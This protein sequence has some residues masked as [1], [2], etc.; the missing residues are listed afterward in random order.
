M[1]SRAEILPE[2]TEMAELFSSWYVVISSAIGPV[3]GCPSSMAERRLGRPSF[4]DASCIL[5][6]FL[7]IVGEGGVRGFYD[8]ELERHNFFF[9]NYEISIH[10]HEI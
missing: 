6:K 8:I 9:Y 1:N 2:T 3:G 10:K 4:R 7:L 5:F